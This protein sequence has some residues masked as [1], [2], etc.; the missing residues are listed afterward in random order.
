MLILKGEQFNFSSQ[1][2]SQ[3]AV[4]EFPVNFTVTGATAVIEGMDVQFA[5]RNDH[6]LGRL[7]VAF[8]C[9][10]LNAGR[11]RVLVGRLPDRLRPYVST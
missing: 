11:V 7:L 1:S 2:Q 4:K 5:H 3:F 10:R 8:S 9:D 6:N